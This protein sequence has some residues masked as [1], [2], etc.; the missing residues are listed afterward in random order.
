MEWNGMEC[1]LVDFYSTLKGKNHEQS[2]STIH[3]PL[4]CKI[5]DSSNKKIVLLLI[6]KALTFVILLCVTLSMST[7]GHRKHS[8]IA[9]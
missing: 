9:S 7:N 4:T 1:R 6:N 3:L 5:I 8:Q 2:S